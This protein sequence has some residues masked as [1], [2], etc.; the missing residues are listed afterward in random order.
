MA[1]MSQPSLDPSGG[2]TPDPAEEPSPGPSTTPVALPSG[3]AGVLN[4]QPGLSMGDLPWTRLVLA[5]VVLLGLSMAIGFLLGWLEDG[6]RPP[7]AS[8]SAHSPRTSSIPAPCAHLTGSAILGRTESRETATPTFH[9]AVPL[10][11]GDRVTVAEGASVTL[12]LAEGSGLTWTGAGELIVTA[13]LVGVPEGTGRIEA[14]PAARPLAVR[15]P[16]VL[17]NPGEARFEVR[18]E[19]TESIVRVQAGKVAWRDLAAS[20]TGV[21]TAPDGLAFSL[22]G[23]SPITGSGSQPVD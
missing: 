18:V 12:V 11:A 9:R 13:G 10:L 22:G 7:T 21:L 19:E 8:P 14:F 3:G 5:G 1:C 16:T 2:P 4:P 6:S 15:L 20:E 17:L 23:R